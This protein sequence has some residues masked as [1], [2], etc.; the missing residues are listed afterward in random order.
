MANRSFLFVPG[1]KDTFITKSLQLPCDRLIFDL[2]DSVPK[3][4]KRD[5]LSSIVALKNEWPSR[6]IVRI[7]KNN[8]RYDSDE[9]DALK[10]SFDL[11]LPK[12]EDKISIER[13]VAQL[14]DTPNCRLWLLIE[15]VIGLWH[16][17]ELVDI[18]T[19]LLSGLVFG[20]EDYIASLDGA[21]I[22]GDRQFIS[23]RTAIVHAARAKGLVCV[24]TPQLNVD[25][26]SLLL[27]QYSDGRGFGFDGALLIHPNQID[28]ANIA[29]G[30]S[31]R[32]ID[33][34]YGIIA[35]HEKALE[36]GHGIGEYKGKIVGP[37]MLERA[38][39][40]LRRSRVE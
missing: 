4:L 7:N 25:N 11:L 2:E 6:H 18:E 28:I 8:G 31:S 3:T 15:T 29:F 27:E 21:H 19:N 40:I 32:E 9:I 24:D 30:C 12:A 1:H 35:A 22:S 34:A 23:A 20:G 17:R 13:V 33:E 14:S 26:S 5:A 37:P 36:N 38:Q 10:G 16:L 39:N